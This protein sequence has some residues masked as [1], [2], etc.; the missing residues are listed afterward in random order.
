MRCLEGRLEEW[1]EGEPLSVETAT[2]AG[3]WR[4]TS[5]DG[6]MDVLRR[7]IGERPTRVLGA[8]GRSI[9]MRS[10]DH[11]MNLVQLRIALRLLFRQESDEL[12]TAL[13]I[14]TH[15]GTVNDSIT[16]LQMPY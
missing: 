9:R 4:S 8:D 2:W 13:T 3:G 11:P 16:E 6:I 12:A 10:G 5:V 15:S 7:K 14:A 1:L